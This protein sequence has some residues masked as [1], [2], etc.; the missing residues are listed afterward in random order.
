MGNKSVPA[1]P[2]KISANVKQWVV[3]V[4]VV[5]A[6]VVTISLLVSTHKGTEQKQVASQSQQV[7]CPDMSADETRS[8]SIGPDWTEWIGTVPGKRV[9]TIYVDQSEKSE[10]NGIV[11]FRFKT[12][13]GNATASYRLVPAEEQC[14]QS[15]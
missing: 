1:P 15:L 13:G 9:C 3:T 12:N 10:K 7:I 5:L 6:V 8:C 2:V 4:I 11:Y 14:P